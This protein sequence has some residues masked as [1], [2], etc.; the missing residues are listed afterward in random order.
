M[1]Y[2][3]VQISGPGFCVTCEVNQAEAPTPQDVPSLALAGALAMVDYQL[4]RPTLVLAQTVQR[5]LELRRDTI[6]TT[7]TVPGSEVAMARNALLDGAEA[8]GLAFAHLGKAMEAH[9]GKS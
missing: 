5:Y 7:N 3:Q 6:P 4:Q 1:D 9:H 2:M 8:V